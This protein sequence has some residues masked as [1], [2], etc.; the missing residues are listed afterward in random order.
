MPSD[1]GIRLVAEQE[2][3]FKAALTDINTSLKTLGSEM[4]LVASEFDKSDTSVAKYAKT[5]EVLAKAIEEQK[6]KVETLK[7]ALA[8]AA[9]GYGENDRRTQAWQQKLNAAQTEL[10]NMERELGE[11][12]KAMQGLGGAMDEAGGKTRTFGDMLKASLTADVIMAGIKTVING[13]KELGSAMLDG[14]KALANT[15]IET[16]RFADDIKTMSVTTGMGTDALQAYSYA[17]GLI[18]TNLETVTGSLA[19]NTRS[20]ESARDGSGAA[21]EAYKKLGISVTDSNGQL[22]NS[23]EVFWQ[24]VDSLGGIAN[25]TERDSIAMS[26]FGKSAQQL[27]PLIAAGSKGFADLT[28]EARSMGAV[29]SGDALDAFGA[30]DDTMVRLTSGSEAVKHALGGILLPQLQELGTVGVSLLREFTTG[31]VSA[32]GDMNKMG[33]VIS[34]ALQSA[35][36]KIQDILP[37]MLELGTQIIQTLANAIQ[38]NLPQI[39]SAA[40]QILEFLVNGIMAILPIIIQAAVSIIMAL[41][42]GIIG[43]LPQLAV[44][45]VQIITAL[46]QGL[47]SALPQLIPA[48]VQAVTQI[49]TGLVENIPMLITAALQLMTGLV[50]GLINA[51]PEIITALPQIIEALVSGLIQHTPEIIMAGVQLLGALALGIPQAILNIVASLPGLIGGIIGGL[52]GFKPNT[53]AAGAELGTSVGE[54]FGSGVNDAPMDISASIEKRVREAKAGVTDEGVQLGGSF[55]NAFSSGANDPTIDLTPIVSG[56]INDAK[57]TVSGAIAGAKAAGQSFMQALTDTGSAIQDGLGKAADFV[58]GV[59]GAVQGGVSSAASAGAAFFGGIGSNIAST[60]TDTIGKAK[61]LVTSVVGSITAGN[62]SASTAGQGLFTAVGS[63]I[64]PAVTN[65]VSRAKEMV[66]NIISSIAGGNSS[67]TSAGAGLFTAIGSNVATAV[68]STITKTKILVNDVI[69]AVKSGVSGAAS[70]GTSVFEA[71]SNNV[72]GAISKAATA[73]GNIVNAIKSG[74]TGAASSLASAG[75][76]MIDGMW[77]GISGAIDSLKSKISSGISGIADKVRSVLGIKSPSKV[78]AEIGMNMGLGMGEG[79]EDIMAKIRRDME[80]AV[81]QNFDT[82]TGL[83]VHGSA[84]S[85][86][87]GSSTTP[88]SGVVIN[89]TITV[90]TPKALSEKELAR[91]FKHLSRQLALSY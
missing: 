61:E 27:N 35:L 48:C 10:N 25:E 8:N 13:I 91:E 4:K 65:T 22:R 50:Q 2:K 42:N 60:I 45:A 1:V 74:I 73:A 33:E 58:S 14:A 31:M 86:L 11:N 36:T 20:M 77:S 84:S 16:A 80:A 34:G 19:R 43:A 39:M 81:P 23:E 75:R 38:Q 12:E 59:V 69:G 72:S 52:L 79:F 88:T 71:I 37:G 68:S 87:Y 29:M 90:T 5:N 17:A 7:L 6:A 18:D 85:R 62:A 76:S 24:V 78:F 70:A 47:A 32:G 89:Q 41:V 28:E 9:E 63:N 21:A 55:S 54:G 3:E 51:I 56:W 82:T 40:Q 26:L 53:Q 30:F 46:V 64:A 57:S 15:T 67:A 44:A 83:N 66:T 49:V